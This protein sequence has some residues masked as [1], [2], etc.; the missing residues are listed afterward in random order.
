MLFARLGPQHPDLVFV[1]FTH[2]LGP[3][4]L[5]LPGLTGK[6]R[7]STLLRNTTRGCVATGTS[8]KVK[9]DPEGFVGGVHLKAFHVQQHCTGVP[10]RVRKKITTLEG[11]SSIILS[12]YKYNRRHNPQILACILNNVE[13]YNGYSINIVFLQPPDFQQCI[14]QYI[15]TLLP[16]G[17]GCIHCKYPM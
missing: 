10:H 13:L 9:Y 3:A 1:Q 4:L 8:K 15:K 2:D 6:A 11:Y 12:S 14:S 7:N 5:N 17:G 16:C